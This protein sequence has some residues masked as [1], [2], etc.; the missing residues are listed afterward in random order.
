MAP[1]ELEEVKPGEAVRTRISRTEADRL[2]EV[3]GR[4]DPVLEGTVLENG[5][6]GLLVDV[7]V[8]TRQ[9]GFRFEPMGQRVRVD[10]GEVLEMER[11]ELDR[12]KT[13]GLVAL[14]GTTV[15]VIGWQIFGGDAG[16]GTNDPSGGNVSD[17]IILP[18]SI[19]VR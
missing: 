14:I 13:T 16:G 11:S 18:I 1:V 7:I 5:P 17:A 8:A 15:G 3:L 10:V 19:R 2:T 9:V 12:W 6:D 4:T